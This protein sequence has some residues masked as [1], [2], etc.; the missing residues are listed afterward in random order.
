MERFTVSQR[1]QAALPP[2]ATRNVSS[3]SRDKL[4]SRQTPAIL[5]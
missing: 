5:L 2:F 3:R 1:K 4:I